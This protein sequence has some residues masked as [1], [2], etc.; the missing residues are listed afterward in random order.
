VVFRPTSDKKHVHIRVVDRRR[1]GIVVATR[2]YETGSG[3]FVREE[4]P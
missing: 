2:V 3:R 4:K 1:A